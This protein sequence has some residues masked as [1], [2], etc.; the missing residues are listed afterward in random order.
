M[1]DLGLESC[2][3]LLSELELKLNNLL[4]LAQI[5]DK[6]AEFRELRVIIRRLDLFSVRRSRA[7][8]LL[9]TG[10]VRGDRFEV[11]VKDIVLLA[12]VFASVP[13]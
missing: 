4:L 7:R 10:S 12:K 6:R 11:L 9:D 1:V 8:R 2:I 5:R 13:L 3:F